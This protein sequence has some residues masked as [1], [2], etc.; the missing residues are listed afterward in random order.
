MI[1]LFTTAL[2][3]GVGYTLGR[4]EGRAQVQKYVS[5]IRELTSR[6]K[7]KRLRE[8]GWDVAG[9][10]VA[11]VRRRL[12]RR[13]RAADQPDEEPAGPVAAVHV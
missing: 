7:A 13:N 6:P 10:Q 5:Q 8:R 3:V 4:P 2:A 9:D 12:D 1:G 11:A